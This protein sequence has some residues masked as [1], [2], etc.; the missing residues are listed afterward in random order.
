MP[1]TAPTSSKVAAPP[2]GEAKVR[3]RPASRPDVLGGLGDLN[4]DRFTHS[5]ILVDRNR[6]VRLMG[7]GGISMVLHGAMFLIIAAATMATPKEEDLIPTEYKAE[8]APEPKNFGGG[9]KFPGKAMI[10]RPNEDDKGSKELDS[11]Q[12]LASQ[13]NEVD[14]MDSQEPDTGLAAIS[15]AGLGRGDVIAFGTGKGTGKGKAIGTRALA[16]GGPG[17]GLWQVGNTNARTLVYV[18]DRSGSMSDTFDSLRSELK[19]AIG[20]LSDQQSFNVIW[21]SEGNAV[22]FA[23][24]LMPATLENKR[25]AFDAVN[26]IV[27]AG[28]TEP[29]DAIKRGLNYAP[30]VMFLLSDGAF[31]EENESVFRLIRDKNRT[32]KTSINTILFIYDTAGDGERVLRNIAEENGGAYKH[33][34]E[35][36]MR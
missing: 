11:L 27:P 16:G 12:D 15:V 19:R 17:G 34:T 22:E 26:R 5:D 20:S 28:Q 25:A 9:F 8:V 33:V 10:D 14:P 13:M 30:D 3:P 36:D 1:E 31:G 21:F 32:K 35:K 23:D 24:K 2:A 29:V 7:S 4:E 6:G 18:L